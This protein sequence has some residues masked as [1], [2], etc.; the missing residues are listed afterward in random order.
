MLYGELP[1]S[2]RK[3]IALL[4]ANVGEVNDFKNNVAFNP[5]L[6]KE[7]KVPSTRNFI[8]LKHAYSKISKNSV[9]GNAIP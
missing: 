6:L 1:T 7:L 8:Q 3:S 2:L 4:Y 9:C 5:F